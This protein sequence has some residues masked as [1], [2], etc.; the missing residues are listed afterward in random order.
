M[1]GSAVP[2]H[3]VTKPGGGH[4]PQSTAATHGSLFYEEGLESPEAEGAADQDYDDQPS[5]D[6]QLPVHTK[7]GQKRKRAGRSKPRAPKPDLR[8]RTWDVV[9]TGLDTLSYDE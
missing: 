3:L 6:D 4:Q 1:L 5:Y 2:P 7:D 9:E 8:K